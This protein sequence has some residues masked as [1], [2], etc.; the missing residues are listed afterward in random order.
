MSP[1]QG[2]PD[3]ASE[4]AVRGPES[5]DG[6][7]APVVGEE[8]TALLAILGEQLGDLGQLSTQLRQPTEATDLGR[9]TGGRG[10]LQLG[11]LVANGLNALVGR[12]G[13][14]GGMLACPALFALLAERVLAPVGVGV[15]VANH[16]IGAVGRGLP[17]CGG[18]LGRLLGAPG[19][20]GRGQHVDLI[21]LLSHDGSV[22]PPYGG[23]RVGCR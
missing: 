7:G 8:G 12:P 20:R 21:G 3:D 18:V 22:L 15:T 14:R 11:E 2:I 6:P 16:A 4:V 9:A 10:G 1:E 19:L 17:P 13:F 23:Y 5:L